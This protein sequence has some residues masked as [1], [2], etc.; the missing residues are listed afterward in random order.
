MLKDI[1]YIK[2][3][4]KKKNKD[5]FKKQSIYHKKSLLYSFKYAGKGIRRVF[6]TEKSFRIQLILG[7]LAIIMGL[8]FHISLI[9][10]L[11]I[12]LII[13]IVLSLEMVNTA[14]ELIIDLVT[15]R[16]KKI[17]EHIKDIAAGAVLFASIV[18]LVV[19]LIIFI[20]YFIALVK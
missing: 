14:F 2:V 7:I 5:S 19:G 18:A 16:Y 12:I 17:A 11:F 6:C 9:E 3:N 13:C 8:L 10:W 20:P 15:E 1:K 4:V